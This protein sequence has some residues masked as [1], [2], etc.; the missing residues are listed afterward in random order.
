MALPL[1]V[2]RHDELLTLNSN[3]LPLYKDAI[4][5][6][7]GVDAQPLFLDKHN[8]AWVLRV[9]FHPGVILPTH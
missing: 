3:D 7:P 8:G 9:V 2:N 5:G 1:L 6:I 4:L